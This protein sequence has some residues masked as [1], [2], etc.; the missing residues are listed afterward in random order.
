MDN[1]HHYFLPHE[2]LQELINAL[3]QLGF[4]CVGPQVR[5]GA[6]VYETLTEAKHLPWGI[7]DHQSPGEYQLETLPNQRAFSWANGPQAIKPLLFKPVETVWRVERSSAGK[8]E[9]KA[10]IADDPPIAVLGARSCDLVAMAIQDKVFISATHQDERYRRRR[11]SLFVIAVN[12][13]YASANCFCV[14]AGTGPEVRSPFDILMTEL[15][16][17][18]VVEGGSKRGKKVIS[19]LNLS[20][21]TAQQCKKAQLE[22]KNAAAMQTKRIPLDNQRGLRD[23]LFANLGHARWEE[24]AERCLSCGN[25]TSVC[26]TCFC[27]SEVTNPSLDGES[28]ELQREWDSCFTEGHSYLAGHPIRDDTRKRYRQWLTHKVG[29][30]FDQFDTSGCVGCGR[31]V[32]WCPVGIDITEELAA[33]SGESNVRE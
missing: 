30:W 11:E 23:L 15:D 32:T 4:T 1:N 2:K 13:G 22:V 24:V 17:G 26:P 28:S 16:S 14:S 19:S 6:I 10:C 9:F 3:Q 5:D 25:C 31:C 27:H 8:L 29:S 12:C 21:A 33:I 18:F 7:R 20:V